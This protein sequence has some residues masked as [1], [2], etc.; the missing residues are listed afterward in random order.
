MSYSLPISPSYRSSIWTSLKIQLVV[1]IPSALLTDTTFGKLFGISLL[2]F[3]P[4][5]V[6]IIARRP[7]SPSAVDLR[8]LRFGFLGIFIIIAVILGPLIWHFRSP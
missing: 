3:W 2:A 8:F 7:L 6:L 1:A 5:A 4:V